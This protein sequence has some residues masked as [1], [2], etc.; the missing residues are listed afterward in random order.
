MFSGHYTRSFHQRRVTLSLVRQTFS[1]RVLKEEGCLLLQPLEQ[2][3]S[4]KGVVRSVDSRGRICIPLSLAKKAH[5]LDKKRVVVARCG[6]ND[7]EI[8]TLPGWDREREEFSK[9]LQ[10]LDTG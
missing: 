5:L 1:M 7:I 9:L 6:R 2:G 8:W 3:T 4:L 10:E